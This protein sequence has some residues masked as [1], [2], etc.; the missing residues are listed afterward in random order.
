MLLAC[1]GQPDRTF[2]PISGGQFRALPKKDKPRAGSIALELPNRN[3][4][5]LN[6]DRG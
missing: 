3:A 1:I 2:V 5:K 4:Y 6:S